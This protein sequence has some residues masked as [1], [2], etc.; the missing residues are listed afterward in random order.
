MPEDTDALE[1]HRRRLENADAVL[2]LG[3]MLAAF[4]PNAPSARTPERRCARR[5]DLFGEAEF[6]E[7]CER[8]VGDIAMNH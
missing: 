6:L 5:A 4:C 1:L 8:V 2:N 7:A 3:A